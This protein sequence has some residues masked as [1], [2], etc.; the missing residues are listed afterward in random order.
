M[1]PQ[2]KRQLLKVACAAWLIGAFLVLVAGLY[3]PEPYGILT[4]FLSFT[5]TAAWLSFW[6]RQGDNPQDRVPLWEMVTDAE[7]ND[8]S[9]AYTMQRSEAADGDAEPATVNL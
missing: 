7:M 4:P 1:K 5:V 9:E 8:R 6:F 3:I 2:R